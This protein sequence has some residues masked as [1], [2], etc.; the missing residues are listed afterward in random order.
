MVGLAILTREAIEDV[1]WIQ[2]SDIDWN[3]GLWRTDPPIMLTPEMRALLEPYRDT[4]G[5]L[6]QSPRILHARPI[7]FYREIL[8]R[9]RMASGVPGAWTMRDVRRATFYIQ[10][11][12]QEWP[13]FFASELAQWRRERAGIYD[14]EL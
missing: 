12:G 1:R 4:K 6:F 10:S 7:H 3:A 9:L 13:L 8:E 2:G 14:V 11:N 5:Y